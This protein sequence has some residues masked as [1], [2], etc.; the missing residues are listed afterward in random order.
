MSTA[1]RA[2]LAQ[3]PWPLSSA[4]AAVRCSSDEAV[5]SRK[6][7]WAESGTRGPASAGVEF[8][9]CSAKQRRACTASA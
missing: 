8:C 1:S 9:C 7:R 3:A 5:R 6:R 2:A 4:E